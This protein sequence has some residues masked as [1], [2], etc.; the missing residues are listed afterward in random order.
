[1]SRVVL[2]FSEEIVLPN[3][4]TENYVGTGGL[5]G[6]MAFYAKQN[7]EINEIVKR[8]ISLQKTVGGLIESV[9]IDGLRERRVVCYA[10]EEGKILELEHNFVLTLNNEIYD[11]VC[12]TAVFLGDSGDGGNRSLT[13]YQIEATR[14]YLEKWTVTEEAK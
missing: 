2:E 10:N 8:F 5:F 4:L 1:M 6:R 7:R 13:K 3:H 12:G 14:N 9:Y 11:I